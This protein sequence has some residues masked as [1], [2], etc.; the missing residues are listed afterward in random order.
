MTMLSFNSERRA[1]LECGSTGAKMVVLV[2][3]P[4][5]PEVGSAF[6]VEHIFLEEVL[7]ESRIKGKARPPLDVARQLLIH[8]NLSGCKTIFIANGAMECC[9]VILPKMGKAETDGAMLLQAKKLVSWESEKPMMAFAGSDFL[10]ERVGYLV[11]LADWKAVKAWGRLIENSG[12]LI[13]DVTLAACAYQALARCQ[14][15]A[16]EFPVFLVADM[17]ATA[18]CFYILDRQAVKFMRKV[19]V[20]GDA[21][22]KILTTVVS[23][24]GGPIQ[25]TDLEAEDVKITGYL[26]L[27]GKKE[28]ETRTTTSAPGAKWPLAPQRGDVAVATPSAP[29]RIEQ[30]E[31][32]ARPVIER[33]TSEIM[34]SVQF[35]TDN[36]GQKVNAV[37]LTGGTAELQILKK[38]LETSVGMPVRVIDPF[39]GMVFTNP[40]TRNY[41]EKHGARL[42][43]ATG[44]ALAE[45]PA[46]SLL[47]RYVHLLKRVAAFMPKAV[48]ALLILGFLPLLVAGTYHAVQIKLV[49]FDIRQYQPSLQQ[50]VLERARRDKLQ[51]QCQE[52]SE[53]VRTLQNMVG[54]NLLWPGMLNAL[55]DAIPPDV[56]LIRC[57][58]GVDPHRPDTILLEGKVLASAAGFDDAMASLLSALGASV[59]FKKVNIVNA[60][61]T[62]AESLRGTFAVQCELVH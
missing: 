59:F 36:A 10:R 39:A 42:A 31:V 32:L 29:K 9:F 48:A 5:S 3:R 40:G 20:G 44:L 45:Q 33:I 27:A 19:P 49:Q 47:P 11:G 38:H 41:A 8:K 54:R 61:A 16:D 12:G 4:D 17:G 55:A 23:T 58:A 26:P 21:I 50:A 13:D 25:L 37:F 60:Q 6:Q 30:M 52:S 14:R 7:F 34:R 56:V 35:F 2:R 24:D 51:K 43:M 46:I 22:T 53:S 28:Q 62:S 57:G 15:W 1:G 18:S